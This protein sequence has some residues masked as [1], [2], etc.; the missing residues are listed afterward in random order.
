L[1]H[2][3]V[4]QGFEQMVAA[5]DL[6]VD[7]VKDHGKASLKVK[8]GLDETQ[9]KTTGQ[10]EDGTQHDEPGQGVNDFA[11]DDSG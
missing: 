7:A 10:G 5:Q 4:V 2:L 9:R 1:V 6:V 8:F 11:H 3:L